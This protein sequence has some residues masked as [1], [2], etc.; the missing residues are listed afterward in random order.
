MSLYSLD[1]SSE[2]KKQNLCFDHQGMKKSDWEDSETVIS[3]VLC[4]TDEPKRQTEA[5]DPSFMGK[6]TVLVP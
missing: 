4:P 3:F 1:T 2:S 5:G 6:L